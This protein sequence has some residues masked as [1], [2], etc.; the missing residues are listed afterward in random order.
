[1]DLPSQDCSDFQNICG[2]NDIN[3]PKFL[4][5]FGLSTWTDFTVAIL[6]GLMALMGLLFIVLFM[7][8]KRTASTTANIIQ[9]TKR[10]GAGVR[11]CT[12]FCFALFAEIR[13]VLL[14]ISF[15]SILLLN[16]FHV[17]I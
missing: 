8:R 3:P 6:I 14:K 2:I 17:I 12:I 1:M 10:D 9:R 5:H 16:Y 15:I 13:Q 4:I 11:F 7:L